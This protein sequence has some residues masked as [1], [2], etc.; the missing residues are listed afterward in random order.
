MSVLAFV[1]FLVIAEM[2]P[3]S[4]LYRLSLMY[5]TYLSPRPLVSR[6]CVCVQ[7]RAC[8]LGGHRVRNLFAALLFVLLLLYRLFLLVHRGEWVWLGS[9]ACASAFCRAC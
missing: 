4:V 9:F 5:E 6:D 3:V 7:L 2:K 1:D 8:F